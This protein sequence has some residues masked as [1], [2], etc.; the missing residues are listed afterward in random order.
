MA[1][2]KIALALIATALISVFSSITSTQP[3]AAYG[4]VVTASAQA[5][6]REALPEAYPNETFIN[7]LEKLDR[8]REKN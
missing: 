3:T 6:V 4:A 1:S 8:K 5:S 2:K 7:T